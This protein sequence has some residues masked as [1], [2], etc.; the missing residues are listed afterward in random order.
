MSLLLWPSDDVTIVCCLP[1]GQQDI[2]GD[3]MV[4]SRHR[5]TTSSHFITSLTVH[6][7]IHWR[8]PVIRQLIIRFTV[9][10]R[11]FHRAQSAAH[12]HASVLV[13]LCLSC[14]EN[15]LIS[16]PLSARRPWI[17][18]CVSRTTNIWANC[19]LKPF[20]ML[21]WLLEFVFINSFNKK[22]N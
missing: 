2:S 1:G 8:T 21:L 9:F 20:I 15:C 19:H 22:K 10:V 13:L 3:V 7:C 4:A 18:Q 17:A 16:R 6:Q 14:V 12:A 5:L 11:T